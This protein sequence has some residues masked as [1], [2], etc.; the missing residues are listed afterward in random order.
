MKKSFLSILLLTLLLLL[1]IAAKAYE[2]PSTC[3]QAL[4]TE[5]KLQDGK[6]APIYSEPDKKSEVKGRFP[7]GEVCEITGR[8]GAFYR[9][10]W[11]GMTVWVPAKGTVAGDADLPCALS[12]EDLNKLKLLGP[13]L[14]DGIGPKA[15]STHAK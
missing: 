14:M 8:E 12:A 5:G 7:K 6:D 10:E 15:V 4:M 3:P 11:E 2:R 1:P 13:G 9:V